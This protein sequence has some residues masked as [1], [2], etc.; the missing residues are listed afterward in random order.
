M[1]ASLKVTPPLRRFLLSTVVAAGLSVQM[2]V[3][4]RSA[5]GAPTTTS[6]TPTSL[7]VPSTA[8]TSI[9]SCDVTFSKS[10][11]TESDTFMVTSVF[12]GSGIGSMRIGADGLGPEFASVLVETTLVGGVYGVADFRAALGMAPGSHT[13]DFYAV[14]TDGAATGVPL[15]R[16]PYTLTGSTPAPRFNGST[17]LPRGSRGTP[18]DN[19]GVHISATAAPYTV[20]R[21]ELVSASHDDGAGGTGGNGGNGGD[22]GFL[23]GNGGSAGLLGGPVES[24]IG[25]NGGNGGNGSVGGNGGSAGLLGGPV[26]AGAGGNG[27]NGSVGGN[28]GNG[29]VGGNAGPGGNGGNGGAGGLFSGT[30]GGNGGAGSVGGSY[31]GGIQLRP[32]SDRLSTELVDTGLNFFPEDIAGHVGQTSCGRVSGT[33]TRAGTYT[34]TMRL[35]YRNASAREAGTAPSATTAATGVH[36]QT[37]ATHQTFTLVIEETPSFTG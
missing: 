33:P 26:D 1:P 12:N 24:G 5:S 27:G 9:T 6:T 19:G 25:G 4:S 7:V 21:C 34:L 30:V 23:W 20:L 15:C 17:E 36:E 14:T 2:V 13:M 16:V 8:Y 10:D 28:G 35:L 31:G 18:Y 29:G 3:S 11:L 37:F 22:G 32:S